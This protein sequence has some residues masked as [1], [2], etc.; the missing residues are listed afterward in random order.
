MTVPAHRRLTFSGVF[1]SIASPYEQWSFRLNMGIGEGGGDP[2]GLT[3]AALDAYTTHLAGLIRPHAILTEVKYAEILAGTT[4]SPGG[5]YAGEPTILAANV[6][7]AAS[8]ATQAPPPQIALAVSL[9]TETR[10][11]SGRGRF[12]LPAPGGGIVVTDGLLA[13]TAAQSV[14][15]SAG[16]FLSAL[17]GPLGFGDVSVISSKGTSAVVTSVRVGRAFDTIRSRRRSILEGYGADVIVNS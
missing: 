14:A 4:L 2:A 6:P 12:Y 7:G 11:A 9:Q 17:N 16:A 8:A 1:G 10:G 13:P 15:T 5:V 3:T